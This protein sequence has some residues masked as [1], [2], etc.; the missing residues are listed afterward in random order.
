M[1]SWKCA[2][3]LRCTG[4]GLE[5]QIHQHGLAAADLAVDVEAL[6]RL[7]A[8]VA[9]AEQPAERGRFARQPMLG[10]PLLEPRNAARTSACAGSAS[11]FPA[12]TSAA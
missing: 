7:A 3:R 8:F 5:E 6:E 11:I 1:N 9:L 4:A 2:R 12:A 10:E